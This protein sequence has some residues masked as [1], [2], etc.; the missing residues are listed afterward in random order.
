MSATLQ[1]HTPSNTL[2]P[3]RWVLFGHILRRPFDNPAN[4]HM[5]NNIAPRH[6]RKWPGRTLTSL[7]TILDQVLR[8]L[9][10]VLRAQSFADTHQLRPYAQDKSK[11]RD[12]VCLL[13][14][15]C[16]PQELPQPDNEFV[17][18]MRIH[19]GRCG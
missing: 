4:L 11:W 15:H 7:P 16:H 10:H 17:P 1:I 5:M 19:S 6:V 18:R 2:L 8:R 14:E 9:N 13:L 12:M 3:S